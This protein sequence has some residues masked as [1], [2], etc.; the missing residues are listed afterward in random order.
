MA[1][2]TKKKKVNVGRKAKKTE[3]N[4]KRIVRTTKHPR[5]V[6]DSSASLIESRTIILSGGSKTVIGTP[7][8]SPIFDI[9]ISDIDGNTTIGDLLVVFP[10]TRDVLFK[11]GVSFDVE[12]A[13]YVYMT[14]NVFSAMH[15]L[16]INSLLEELVTASKEVAPAQ[17]PQSPASRP[18]AVTTTPA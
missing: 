16:K 17:A 15:G 2:V 13:G 11:H 1:K 6:P 9:E 7:D 12:E 10:R 8:P 3:K 14:L 5:K 4:K 18:L